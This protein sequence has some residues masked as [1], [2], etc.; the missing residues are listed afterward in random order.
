ML[1]TR[2]AAPPLIRGQKT[3]LRPFEREDVDRW[4]EWPRHT[5]PLFGD[6]NPPQ[7]TPRQR[8][9]Y[10]RSRRDAPDRRMF[11]VEDERGELI[12]RLSLRGIDE[13]ARTAVLGISFSP[14]RLDRG[15]GTDALQAFLRYYFEV[16]G[17]EALFLDVAAFNTRARRVYEKCGFQV[18]GHRWGEAQPD[19]AGVFQDP[20]YAAIRSLFRREGDR[21][22][23][24]MIDMVLRRREFERQRNE[25][26]RAAGS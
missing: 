8:D 12:G 10:F 15:Y 16:L 25:P 17:M 4:L 2:R 21:I 22:R 13:R 20:R 19:S 9:L 14:A 5:N 3:T 23:P 11:T 24:L 1:F 18:I 6:Y 7:M 26:Q